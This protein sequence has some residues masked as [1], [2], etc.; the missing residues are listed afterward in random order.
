MLMAAF[1]NWWDEDQIGGVGMVSVWYWRYWL[2]LALSAPLPQLAFADEPIDRAR[3]LIEQG[4]AG[5]AFSVLD[6]LEA[7]R[8]GDVEYDLLF[9]ISAVDSGQN[10]RGVFA[11]ERVLATQ[12]ENA[13]ARA[14]IARAYLALGETKTAKKEFE[15]VQR[16]G[17]T[18]EVS[19]TIDR[20]LDA[21][22]KVENVSRTTVRGFV[23]GALGYDTNVNAGPGK[24]TINMAI[25]AFGGVLLP[26]TLS[27]ES[28]AQDAGF[29][30]LGAGV[31]VRTPLSARSA[32]VAGLSGNGRT[33]FGET[34]YDNLNGDLYAGYV[35]A[36]D[37]SVFS[38]NAQFNQYVLDD[39]R[40]RSASGVSAQWQY[41]HDTRNQFSLFAQYSELKYQSLSTRDADRWV[42]G[43][44]YAHA[45]RGG[46]V[47]Y[48]SVYSV[49][50]KPQA[51]HVSWLGFDG[52]GVRVGGQMNVNAR[53]VLFATGSLEHRRYDSEDPSF[54][55]TRR[56]NQYDVGVG[57]NYQ[58]A[59]DW[60]ITPKVNWTVN[61]SNTGINDYRRGSASV[62][63]RHDF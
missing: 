56:D 53:T 46:E 25:P 36:M 28:R 29:A 54:L 50:E 43:G 9:G 41:T 38:L 26:F 21:V 49:S 58:P 61:D 44:A 7:E 32:L 27:K 8:A 35:Y 37:R 15:T 10:T 23:E 57:L 31:N 42:V 19:A 6:P 2:L 52:V 33:N 1:V 62:S 3:Q 39:Q 51:S 30:T 48:G 63:V 45:F 59:R 20:Y 5:E 4:K 40:Y 22:D 47:A 14:E 13:R 11:L 55:V 12:P 60:L 16:Q 18:P 17:V 24:G 34:Q